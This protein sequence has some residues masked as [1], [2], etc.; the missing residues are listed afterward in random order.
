MLNEILMWRG[1][2]LSLF[3]EAYFPIWVAS[4]QLEFQVSKDN[5]LLFLGFL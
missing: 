5:D 1:G 2:S 4:E 3:A